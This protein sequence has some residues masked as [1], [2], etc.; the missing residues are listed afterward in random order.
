MWNKVVVLLG[1]RGFFLRGVG[2]GSALSG[3][4]ISEVLKAIASFFKDS[5]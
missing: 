5:T 4:V 1:N 3:G 2:G